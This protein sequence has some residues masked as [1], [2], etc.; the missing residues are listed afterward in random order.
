M[1]RQPEDAVEVLRAVWSAE[2]TNGADLDAAVGGHR[3]HCKNAKHMSFE[4]FAAGEEDVR[5]AW[6]TRLEREG[7]LTEGGQSIRDLVLGPDAQH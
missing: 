1:T 3:K 6:R 4:G 2:E 5:T 7:K